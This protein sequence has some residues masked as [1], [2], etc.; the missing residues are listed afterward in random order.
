VDPAAGLVDPALLDTIC[1]RAAGRPELEYCFAPAAPG[2]CGVLLRPALLERLAATGGHPGRLL[3]YHPDQLSREPLAG[4]AC[5]A[6]PPAVA[7]TTHRFS[8][9]S[10]RQV[11][12]LAA[13]TASL[14]GQLARASAED[15][16]ARLATTDA[17]DPLPREV[18]L[19][20]TT[21]RLSR[22]VFWPG[23]YHDIRRPDLPTTDAMALVR[24]LSAL[25][26]TRLT[27]SGVGDPLLSPG[28][29]ETIE[30]ASAAG[31]S[32]HVE[33]DL[34]SPEPGNAR[35]LAA[36]PADVV[37]VHLPALNDRTYEAVMGVDGYRR[38]LENLRE[39]VTERAARGSGVPVLAPV[40]T[41]CAA[42]LAEMEGWYDQWLR[43]VGS[44]VIAGPSHFEG[45]TPDVSVADMSPPRRRPCARL[46]SRLTVLCDGRIVSCEQDVL[47]QQVL[48]HLGRDALSE[49]W[50]TRIAALREEH[51]CGN[52]G[53]RP[54]CGSCREWH[55][56]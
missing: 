23:R 51:R 3:H 34:L 48:G 32:V 46:A 35:R 1:D 12:R 4:E 6:V 41:K 18:V 15:L 21:A 47:G 8:L 43:A 55:R 16:V 56:P 2:L 5:A 53:A 19:E 50:Q 25:D 20:L 14:N 29:F 40:F 28:V 24:Q 44:A 7:R 36:S 30:A 9:S 27:L 39:F 49:V 45:L 11:E 13:A 26:D 54:L 42:N 52:W 10:D 17:V 37:S 22:P 33:T 31:L 38:V